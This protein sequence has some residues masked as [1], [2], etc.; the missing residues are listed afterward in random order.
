MLYSEWEWASRITQGLH[1]HSSGVRATDQSRH[2]L[3]CV[4]SWSVPCHSVNNSSFT[5]GQTRVRK[6]EISYL[7]RDVFLL[8]ISPSWPSVLVLSSPNPAVWCQ[9]EKRSMGSRFNLV[10]EHM[11]IQHKL[12][13][14]FVDTKSCFH[15]RKDLTFDVNKLP[16]VLAEGS[17][18]ISVKRGR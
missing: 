12:H 10:R 5:Q 17:C 15:S 18:G 13:T 4:A 8:Q 14:H 3:S 11:E 2:G 6:E 1:F 16:Y 7:K 9:M